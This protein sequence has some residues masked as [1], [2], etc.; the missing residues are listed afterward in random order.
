MLNA[1]TQM[2]LQFFKTKVTPV[3]S[4]L[5]VFELFYFEI[6]SFEWAALLCFLIVTLVNVFFS[7]NYFVYQQTFEIEDSPQEIE[8]NI[9]KEE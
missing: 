5:I 7:N 2:N 8:N 3:V 4:I 1:I 6:V 9:D